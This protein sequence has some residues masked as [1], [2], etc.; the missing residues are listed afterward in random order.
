MKKTINIIAIL[1]MS[2]C[3]IVSV[4]R[5]EN[6]L[7]I[8]IAGV[9]LAILLFFI[10]VRKR[11]FFR[12]KQVA[13][14]KTKIITLAIIEVIFVGAQ[15]LLVKEFTLMTVLYIVFNIV[16]AGIMFLLLTRKLDYI[17]GVFALAFIVLNTPLMFTGKFN[18]FYM[19]GLV[20]YCFSMMTVLEEYPFDK[21][22]VFKYI[23]IGLFTGVL[24][25]TTYAILVPT[26]L[27][28]LLFI[29]KVGKK[30]ALLITLIIGVVCVATFFAW[31]ALNNAF[32]IT[33]YLAFE[34]VELF[35][36]NSIINTIAGTILCFEVVSTFIYAL[37]ILIYDEDTM[38]KF[39]VELYPLVI[40][41]ALLLTGIIENQSTAYIN[42]IIPCA[43][44]ILVSYSLKIR[45]IPII[46]YIKR[47]IK[48]LRKKKVSCVIPNY[49]YANYI[50]N[51]IDS[52]V[53]QTYPLYELIVLDDKSSDNSVEV[54]EKKLEEIKKQHPQ[55]KVK[56]IPNKENSGSVFKQWE[57]AFNNFTGDY[58]WIAE[59]DDLCNKYF[60]NVVM[61][62]F[63]NKKVV[64]SYAESKMMDE[65]NQ[66]TE[67]DMR[68]VIDL[69][70]TYRYDHDY[71]NKGKAEL[72]EILCTN[73][74]IPNASGVVFKRNDNADYQKYLK[75]AQKD[76]RLSGDWYF[77]AKVLL[78]GKIAYSSDS[79]NY[80]RYHTNNVTNTTKDLIR[81][82]EVL[83]V[84]SAV[85]K[86][87]NLSEDAIERSKAYVKSL[88][89]WW[90][91][92]D[93]DLQN[94]KIK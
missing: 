18:P 63:R 53:N 48:P 54:I 71:I 56:F 77:Y 52:V 12:N 35:H 36:V 5:M 93:E 68:K 81:L 42:M 57:K 59:A 83:K 23:L 78:H 24:L 51:R 29:D 60:L 28:A 22:S 79:L 69:E 7:I 27:F 82:R 39:D 87:I 50:E 70:K 45:D 49:N 40:A 33:K 61:K 30:K 32:D 66:I 4:V 84:Q 26:V 21:R 14:R 6:N 38:K 80:H 92:S 3:F 73:N 89:Y 76:F 15:V 58:L 62:G 94:E 25:N 17:H 74:S 9:L 55:L 41:G 44:T 19:F 34:N 31:Q 16:S 37:V 67:E 64:L 47:H 8:G 10:L 43:A 72:E 46:P 2:I 88:Q 1:M 20:L 91:I 11:K 13:T 90:H 85:S 86:D 65:N 75:E